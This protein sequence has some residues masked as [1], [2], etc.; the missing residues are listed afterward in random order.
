M[1]GLKKDGGIMV[2]YNNLHFDYPI[3]HMMYEMG[4]VLSAK[5]MYDKKN[6]IFATPFNEPF[7][8]TIWENR[9]IVLS[10]YVVSQ[11]HFYTYQR[12]TQLL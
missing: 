12:I 2:G 8:H 7:R 5:P 9:H 4:K 10:I 6:A 3:I 11:L 1:D